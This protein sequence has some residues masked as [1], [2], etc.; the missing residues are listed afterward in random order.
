[1][2]LHGWRLQGKYI[3]SENSILESVNIA[4][5]GEADQKHSLNNNPRFYA[6]KGNN[7]NYSDFSHTKLN[8]GSWWR[9][10]LHREY[11]IGRIELF[12]RQGENSEGPYC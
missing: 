11:F 7:G 8:N 12:N 1:M 6:A 4:S 2:L 5:Q 3:S 10:D 9:V